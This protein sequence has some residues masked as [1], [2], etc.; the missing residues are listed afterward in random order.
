MGGCAWAFSTGRIGLSQMLFSKPG[1]P[2]RSSFPLS[3]ADLYRPSVKQ[4]AEPT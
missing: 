3:R 1:L 2:G 4:T